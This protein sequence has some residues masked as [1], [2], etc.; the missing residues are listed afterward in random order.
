MHGD[1]PR[2]PSSRFCLGVTIRSLADS[3]FYW[4]KSMAG[5]Y[6]E[7]TGLPNGDM[8]S[9]GGKMTGYGMGPQ[10]YAG[11]DSEPARPA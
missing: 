3:R 1:F 9:E 7:E 2:A 11:L 10:D 4:S 6:L 5:G 8:Y